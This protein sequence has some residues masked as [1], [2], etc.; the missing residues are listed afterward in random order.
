M[1]QKCHDFSGGG[2]DLRK[3]SVLER[4]NWDKVDGGKENDLFQVSSGLIRA[5]RLTNHAQ[6]CEI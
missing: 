4:T 2:F 1:G 6:V 3:S 5:G